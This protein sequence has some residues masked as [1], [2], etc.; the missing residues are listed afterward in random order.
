MQAVGTSSAWEVLD[1]IEIEIEIEIAG[2]AVVEL[3]RDETATG[4]TV[5]ARPVHS[6]GR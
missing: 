4:C 6:P 3:V 1:G 5:R 2:D